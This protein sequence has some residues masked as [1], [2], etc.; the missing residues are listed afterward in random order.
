MQQN[1]LRLD[2][3]MDDV[4]PVRVVERV[5]YITHDE[6][7]VVERELVLAIEPVAKRLPSTKGMT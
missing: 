6:R 3:P 4:A 5:G 1:V 7:Y 2:V